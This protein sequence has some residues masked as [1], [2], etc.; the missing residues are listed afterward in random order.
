[1]TNL[2]PP[3]YTMR[4]CPMCGGKCGTHREPVDDERDEMVVYHAHN[5]G[6]G[7]PCRMGGQR[8]AIRAVAFTNTR[9]T[10]SDR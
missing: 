9:P 4:F 10:R 3:G 2:H 1:M 5:D 8:A 7:K 6:I